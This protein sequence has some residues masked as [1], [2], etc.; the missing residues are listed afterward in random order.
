MTLEPLRLLLQAAEKLSGRLIA[1][2]P[3]LARLRDDV[4]ILEAALERAVQ[5]DGGRNFRKIESDQDF[6]NDLHGTTGPIPVQRHKVDDLLPEQAAFYRACLAAGFPANPDHNRPDATG[7]GPYP[8]NNP[9]GIRYS[10]ALGYL[11]LARHRLN[12]TIQARCMTRRILFHSNRAV[13]VEVERGGETFVVEGEKIILSAGTIGSPHLLML[14][15]VGPASH[16]H[17]LGIPV[18]H[19]A[20]GIGQ[21]CATIRACTYAGTSSRIFHLP[22]ALRP[23]RPL[24]TSVVAKSHQPLPVGR[25]DQLSASGYVLLVESDICPDIPWIFR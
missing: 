9:D 6:Q 2:E 24:P 8:L 25:R 1:R 14:A 19:D 4:H 13:G 23:G 7:V 11:R 15:G 3:P 18:V 17:S 21:T 22:Q 10:T 16:L 5:I 20:P 12:L